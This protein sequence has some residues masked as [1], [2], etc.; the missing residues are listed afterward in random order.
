MRF[1]SFVHPYVDDTERNKQPYSVEAIMKEM[2]NK[3]T[4][5]STTV[6]A[7]T[8]ILNI[9]DVLNVKRASCSLT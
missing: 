5:T 4:V 6:F 2:D 1:F 3:F 7:L 8:V 9:P